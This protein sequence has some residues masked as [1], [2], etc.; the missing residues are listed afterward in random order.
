MKKRLFYT[1][2]LTLPLLIMLHGYG[3][4][5]ILGQYYNIHYDIQ[6]ATEPY[7]WQDAPQ[8]IRT[9]KGHSPRHS[10]RDKHTIL[11]GNLALP[12]LACN[13]ITSCATI[14]LLSAIAFKMLTIRR[15]HTVS[16]RNKNMGKTI[17][18]LISRKK[19]LPEQEKETL[20]LKENTLTDTDRILFERVNNE[21]MTRRLFLA[22]DFSKK[23]F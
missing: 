18:I 14:L 22:P 6:R 17:G 2:I 9:C 16:L 23:N 10:K 5:E 8:D 1:L 7:Y 15:C 11:A 4:K 13:V 3:Q 20:S 19:K 12:V 21:I